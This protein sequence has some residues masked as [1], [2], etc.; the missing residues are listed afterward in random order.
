M[1]L[2][3]PYEKRRPTTAGIFSALQF[4]LKGVFKKITFICVLYHIGWFSPILKNFDFQKF[5]S[6]QAFF[7][8]FPF[9]TIF[10]KKATIYDSFNMKFVP[11]QFLKNPIFF[12]KKPIFPINGILSFYMHSTATFGI[13]T[14]CFFEKNHFL[15]KDMSYFRKNVFLA[16]F[17]QKRFSCFAILLQD[18]AILVKIPESQYTACKILPCNAFLARSR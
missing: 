1:H 18:N 6:R 16:R 8:K 12:L 7:W 14:F 13:G 15:K 4:C 2:A 3:W 5:W 10:L 9:K 11:S 17:V